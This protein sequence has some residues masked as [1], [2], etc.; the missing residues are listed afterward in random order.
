MRFIGHLPARLAVILVF[1]CSGV[2][3]CSEQDDLERVTLTPATPNRCQVQY[4]IE[5]GGDLVFEEDSQTPRR[6]LSVVA[7]LSYDELRLAGSEEDEEPLRAVRMYTISKAAIKIDDGG[8]RLDLRPNR[9]LIGVELNGSETNLF[10]P[11]GSLTRRELDLIETV[12]NSLRIDG[13]LPTEAVGEGDVWTLSDKFV[14]GFL[15]LDA[16]SKAKVDCECHRDYR[17]SRAVSVY[18]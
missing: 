7:E 1:L 14:A 16:V 9:R 2:G 13:L 8:R 12:A 15:D 6:K 3:V 10:S 11:N 5:V 18:R 17:G 4:V